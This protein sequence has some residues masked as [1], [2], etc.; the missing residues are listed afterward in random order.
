MNNHYNLSD[1]EFEIQFKNCALDPSIFNHEAH[2]RLAWIHIIKY[3]IE[4]AEENIHHQL[5]AYVKSLG[6]EE[7][8]NKT[9]TI[10]A[11]KAVY[12]FIQKSTST[13]FEAFISEFPRLK[14]NFKELMQYH[15]GFDIF[16]LEEAKTTFLEPNLV[17][18]S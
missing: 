9:L 18:F 12:H 6:A 8:Y 3:G 1:T 4:Q 16:T 11:I 10:A 13:D 7:K 14:F 2:L 17:P 15:Y 5:L